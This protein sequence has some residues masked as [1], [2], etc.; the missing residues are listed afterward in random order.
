MRWRHDFTQAEHLAIESFRP[1]L[2]AARHRHLDV[3]EAQNL[4]RLLRHAR[5]P[6]RDASCSAT[7]SG[8]T[9][10]APSPPCD[11]VLRVARGGARCSLTSTSVALPAPYF[12]PLVK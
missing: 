6:P 10:C 5:S 9:H 8:A 1:L 2:A 12:Q 11:P 4:A 7:S 3:I